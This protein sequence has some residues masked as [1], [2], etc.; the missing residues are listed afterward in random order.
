[1]PD[2]DNHRILELANTFR[3]C[4]GNNVS[5]QIKRCEAED[6]TLGKDVDIL[7]N[8]NVIWADHINS[9]IGVWKYDA[10]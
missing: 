9:N 2:E 4:Y 7:E 3:N 1:M 8:S 5:P 10:K 6:L